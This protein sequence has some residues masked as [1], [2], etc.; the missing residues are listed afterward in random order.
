[1]LD[2]ELDLNDRKRI[3]YDKKNNNKKNLNIWK[4]HSFLL[5]SSRLRLYKYLR[6]AYYRCDTDHNRKDVTNIDR[7]FLYEYCCFNFGFL[8]IKNDLLQLLIMSCYKS[9]QQYKAS[10]LKCQGITSILTKE[11]WSL[12]QSVVWCIRQNI[13][14]T[15]KPD[16]A[17]ET[18]SYSCHTLHEVY[19]KCRQAHLKDMVSIW[20]NYF[21]QKMP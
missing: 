12:L 7:C 2:N 6:H 17:A 14:A 1:M 11:F 13:V 21:K 4:R 19:P 9:R 20:N 10:R 15:I 18:I 16:V 3:W 8:T 5:I